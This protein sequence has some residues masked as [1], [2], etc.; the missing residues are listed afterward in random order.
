MLSAKMDTN[1]AASLI[2]S[3]LTTTGPTT[4]NYLRIRR[5]NEDEEVQ[6]PQPKSV[7]EFEDPWNQ[8]ADFDDIL[9]VTNLVCVCFTFQAGNS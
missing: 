6:N 8:D 1:R 3:E 9:S 2:Y 5:D 7:T 4:S